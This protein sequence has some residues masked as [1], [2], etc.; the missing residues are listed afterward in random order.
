MGIL[1]SDDHLDSFA[2][3]K[4]ILK[5]WLRSRKSLLARTP[6][7][8]SMVHDQNLSFGKKKV[9][10]F[11]PP[12]SP[13]QPEHQQWPAP[14]PP[15]AE[16]AMLMRT[17]ASSTQLAIGG[18]TFVSLSIGGGRLCFFRVEGWV[19]WRDR[20]SLGLGLQAW[21]RAAKEPRHDLDSQKPRS[22]V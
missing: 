17:T 10:W 3:L 14:F 15:L 7:P 2:T 13:P 1:L 16:T 5:V 11:Q 9:G 20:D 22:I 18:S 6:A 21:A 12:S 4:L 8:S 19:F